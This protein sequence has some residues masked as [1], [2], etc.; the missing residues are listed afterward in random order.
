MEA[1]ISDRDLR[2][3]KNLGRKPIVTQSNV[4]FA[5][6]VLVLATAWIWMIMSIGNTDWSHLETRL[7]NIA[8]FSQKALTVAS[9]SVVNGFNAVAQW[10]LKEPLSAQASYIA[11]KVEWNVMSDNGRDTG[12]TWQMP[13]ETL[14]VI[15]DP[16]LHKP[17]IEEYSIDSKLPAYTQQEYR[18]A[19][20]WVVN[21]DDKE[22]RDHISILDLNWSHTEFSMDGTPLLIPY[23]EWRI[24]V[25]N[26][27]Y[28]F[29]LIRSHYEGYSQMKWV[30]ENGMTHEELIPFGSFIKIGWGTGCVFLYQT[31]DGMI[32]F[33]HPATG[34]PL[35]QVG[36]YA[37]SKNLETVI[38]DSETAVP[39]GLITHEG[40]DEIG[41][42]LW[43]LHRKWTEKISC[44]ARWTS[45][46]LCLS[47]E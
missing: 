3:I 33:T 16:T 18:L 46:Y 10:L 39:Y 40:T 28:R 27:P 19:D 2:I 13:T 25:N 14:A 43:L 5:L 34:Y 45:S 44:P 9:Q 23:S 37:T 20:T 24:R 6:V 26:T 36:F 30:D 42:D 15:A 12:Y 38:V 29:E 47:L 4:L 8:E 32:H 7:S 41:N 35:F 17:A 1:Q 31:K 22:I 11:P 21:M